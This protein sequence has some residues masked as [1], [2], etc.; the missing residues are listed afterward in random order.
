MA[1]GRAE[2]WCMP[3]FTYPA[4]AGCGVPTVLGRPADCHAFGDRRT[5]FAQRI[6]LPATVARRVARR[7]WDHWQGAR[8]RL[9]ARRIKSPARPVS[10][11]RRTW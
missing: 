1:V 11:R 3:G 9:A 10:D 2:R 7:G 4:D 6:A 8:D 5:A